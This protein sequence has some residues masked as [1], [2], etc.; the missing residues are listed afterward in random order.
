MRKGCSNF[1]FGNTRTTLKGG[2]G[3]GEP[4][5]GEEVQS[6]RK[7]VVGSA[8]LG[9]GGSAADEPSLESGH[10]QERQGQ[11]GQEQAMSA[12]AG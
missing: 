2:G 3:S 10:E 6:V 8:S 4:T 12:S 7:D 1:S 11:H 5:T 9:L